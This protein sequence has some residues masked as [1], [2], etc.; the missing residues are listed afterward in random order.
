MKGQR[1]VTEIFSILGL[2]VVLI[3]LIPI[4][5]PTIQEAIR[6]FTLDSPEI[7]SKDLASL[8]S[9]SVAAPGN[10]LTKYSTPSGSLYDVIIADKMVTVSR[11]LKDKKQESSSPIPVDLRGSFSNTKDFVI[12]KR[13]E[14]GEEKYYINDELVADFQA[15]ISPYIP[16]IPGPTP[17]IPSGPN[18]I[19]TPAG[20]SKLGIQTQFIHGTEMAFIEKT[21]PAV[22]KI[23]N[24]HFDAAQQIKQKSPNTFIIGR[25]FS[26]DQ[27]MDGNPETRAE[28]WFNRYSGEISKYS[29]FDCWEGY[30]EPVVKDQTTMEWLSRFEIK[31]M[32]LLEGIGRRACIGT[33]PVGIPEI[34]SPGDLWPYFKPALNYA[35]SHGHYLA[36]HEGG[37]NTM[38]QDSQWMSLRHRMVYDKY[39]EYKLTLPLL[40]TE[41]CIDKCGG[42]DCGW[43]SQTNAQDYLNQLA[44]YDSE[45]QK[46]SYVRGAA[47]YHYGFQGWESFEIFPELTGNDGMSGPLVK[48]FL[49]SHGE[50][51]DVNLVNLYKDSISLKIDQNTR[52]YEKINLENDYLKLSV[53]PSLGG[54]IYEIINKETGNDELYKNPSI[55]TV[56]S[57]GVNKCKNGGWIA[58][59]G[60]EFDF[61]DQEHGCVYDQPWNYET[62][63]NSD[64]SKSIIIS[65]QTSTK[66]NDGT[67]D[68]LMKATVEINL[69]PGKK[70]FSL[71]TKIENIGSSTFNYQYW[72]NAMVSPGKTDPI[73]SNIEFVYPTD[74]MIVHSS[75]FLNQPSTPSLSSE[76]LR[77][78]WT[79]DYKFYDN[80]KNNG[81]LG[82]FSE[83]PENYVSIYSHADNEGLVR[84][85]QNGKSK[86]VK[87]FGL[88]TISSSTFTDDN[89]QYIEMWG[90]VGK[91]FF[92]DDYQ[93]LNPGQNLEWIEFWAPITNLNQINELRIQLGS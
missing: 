7:I 90:G 92:N 27:P 63:E 22:V 21:K 49:K 32:Q 54:R 60:I 29:G 79:D 69:L 30:N 23:M 39:P 70:Y 26:P 28:E 80:W 58:A 88:G 71:K 75:N 43:R 50:A 74:M 59:G 85:F 73:N 57:W 44:W 89:S 66:W 1:E 40:I 51:V 64:G 11:Q 2:I 78:T 47:I 4:I 12:E 76:A 6:I 83:N 61:P 13:V 17:T 86:G 5:I 33:F 24:A 37:K 42:E 53:L 36:L 19:P 56:S 55:K 46:D 82:A 15:S 81:W 25:I 84:I 48:Y 35:S 77:I 18:V 8:I 45:L 67:N 62:K 65:K 91:T 68:G 93:T 72:S 38:Q 3:A 31:R 14:G 9:A 34:V 41:A 52:D 16:L 10:I 87:L 20:P